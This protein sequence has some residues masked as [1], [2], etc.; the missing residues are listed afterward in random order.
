MTTRMGASMEALWSARLRL[1][2]NALERTMSADTKP[3]CIQSVN[4]MA[5]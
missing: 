5:T 1:D 2:A 3:R 4:I